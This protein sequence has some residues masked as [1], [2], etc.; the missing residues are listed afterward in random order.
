MESMGRCS[1]KGRTRRHRLEYLRISATALA[2]SRCKNRFLEN[3]I[4]RYLVGPRRNP[5]KAGLSGLGRFFSQ[6]LA[7]L[8]QVVGNRSQSDPAFHPIHSPIATAEQSV[9]AFQH[10]DAPF[11]AHAPAL[12][13]PEPALALM[14]PDGPA[15][16]SFVGH[17]QL[18]NPLFLGLRLVVGTEEARVS[19]HQP[20]KPV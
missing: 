5:Q 16:C 15:P 12:G 18:L 19:R 7:D 13:S 4:F 2:N 8:D 6:P 1:K 10:A 11:T 3:S 9:F 20:G 14:L 17:G